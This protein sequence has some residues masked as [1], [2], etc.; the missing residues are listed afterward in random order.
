ML[1]LLLCVSIAGVALGCSHKPAAPRDGEIPASPGAAPEL[2]AATEESA[3]AWISSG[4]HRAVRDE[5]AVGK[6]I[7]HLSVASTLVTDR[8]VRQ[9][10]MLPNLVGLELHY[11]RVTGA[12]LQS[13]ASLKGLT[14][15]S[16]AYTPLSESDMIGLADQKG[17]GVLNLTGTGVADGGIAKLSPLTRLAEL[18]LADCPVGDD[19][20]PFLARLPALAS[21]NLAGTRV[22]DAGLKS[23]AG[24]SGLKALKLRGVQTADPCL[25]ALEAWK[26]LTSLTLTDYQGT[27]G[28]LAHLAKLSKLDTLHIAPDELN[29]LSLAQLRDSNL[30]HALGQAKGV[31]GRRPSKPADVVALQFESAGLTDAGLKVFAAFENLESLKLG[32]SRLT[33]TGLRH[34]VGLKRLTELGL[35]ST[36]V[37][38]AAVNEFMRDRPE[39][40]ITRTEYA[41]LA[42]ERARGHRFA[43]IIHGL[44]GTVIL[45]KTQ[46]HEPVAEAEIL[47][48]DKAVSDADL[49]GI[50][51]IETLTKLTLTNLYKVTVV[52]LK[53]LALLPNLTVL[54][55]DNF[56]V[57]VAG[58]KVLTEFKKLHTLALI[59]TGA[60]DA[61]VMELHALTNLRS[62]LLSEDGLT[63]AAV[64]GL[65]KALPKCRITWVRNDKQLR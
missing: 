27:P 38:D 26:N 64:S 48:A 9:I 24:A 49:N 1:R 46:P 14:F 40:K 15:L 2:P 55:L 3:L 31:G 45:D 51:T 42:A 37:T 5:T 59:H 21:L 11:T 6:P 28:G 20:M 65:E 39:C 60:T 7:I 57:D 30:L 47:G 43:S 12:G 56:R 29:D 44:G 18:N 19:S 25:E 53:E 33:D 50:A 36:A 8:D 61:G 32:R 4:P 16:L 41:K 58:L 23:L 54:R 17:I 63:E 52:G 13:L 22:T 10:A 35:D 34:L 62:L